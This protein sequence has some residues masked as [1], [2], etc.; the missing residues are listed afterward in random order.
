MKSVLVFEHE[1]HRNAG[2]KQEIRYLPV[3]HGAACWDNKPEDVVGRPVV[4]TYM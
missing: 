4:D 3:M 1:V 2:A